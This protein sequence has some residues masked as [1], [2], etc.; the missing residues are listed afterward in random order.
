MLY[1]L[2][3]YVGHLVL[4][5]LTVCNGDTGIGKH[6]LPTLFRI[7]GRLGLGDPARTG[8]LVGTIS[9]FYPVYGDSIRLDGV[10]DRKETD[11]YL[12]IKG[13][14]RLG[15]FVGAALA[16]KPLQVYGD[17]G[18]TRCFCHVADVVEALLGLLEREETYGQ[19]YNIGS[20]ENISIRDLAKR[21][22]ERTCSSSGIEFVPYDVAYAAGFEDMRHRM[23]DTSKIAKLIGWQPRHTLDGIID[24][25]ADDMRRRSAAK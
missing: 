3:P 11:L 19:V 22:I 24:D 23:P 6:F 17:G 15:I 18:Q 2:F 1:K 10:Y 8:R 12:H 7:E 20:D 16:G 25:V 5:H 13:R 4:A 21:V 9:A 14:I